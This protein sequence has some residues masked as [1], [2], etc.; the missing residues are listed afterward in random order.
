[1]KCLPGCRIGEA[2]ENPPSIDA[3]MPA[4]SFATNGETQ[5]VI[6]EKP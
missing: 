3:N 6:A 1:M 2:A 4:A 5:K